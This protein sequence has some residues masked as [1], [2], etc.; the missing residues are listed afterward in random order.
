[1]VFLNW[2]CKTITFKKF[3]FHYCV[4]SSDPGE[5]CLTESCTSRIPDLKA[6][7]AKDK[8]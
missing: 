4:I 6:Y 1:M 5:M 2:N 8:L 7:I 3:S